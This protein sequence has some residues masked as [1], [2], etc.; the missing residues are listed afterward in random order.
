MALNSVNRKGG[1]HPFSIGQCTLSQRLLLGVV[2]ATAVVVSGFGCSSR[3]PPPPQMKLHV[4]SDR[5]TNDGQLFYLV[6]RAIG[7]KQFLTDSYQA[8]AGIVFA[9]PPDKTIIASH[10]IL[11]GEKQE[12]QMIQPEESPVAFYFLFTSP[13]DQWKKILDQPLASAYNISIRKNEVSIT[14][15][16]SLWKRILWPFGP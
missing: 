12:F 14:R 5:A 3:R 1:R 13:G 4:Q 9:D 2:L 10:V 15:Q 16:R 6:V 8:V 7:D 11:P